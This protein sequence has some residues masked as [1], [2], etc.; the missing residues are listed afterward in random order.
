MMTKPRIER[1]TTAREKV[2]EALLAAGLADWVDLNAVHCHVKEERPSATESEVQRETLE[3]IRSLVSDGLF[4]LGDLSGEH[5]RFAAWD[6]PLDESIQKISDVYVTHYDDKPAWVWFAWM[7]LTD[8]GKRVAAHPAAG[9][10]D[11][12]RT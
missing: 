3:M 2:R 4:T 10:S 12:H 6:E 9:L 1:M 11:D 8:K 5:G 7:E